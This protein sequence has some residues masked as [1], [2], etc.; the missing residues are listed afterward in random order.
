MNYVP[1]SDE[2]V[3]N[4]KP[5]YDIII[6]LSLTKWI[7]LNWGDSGLKRFFKKVYAHLQP[8][9]KF[10]LEPQSFSSYYKRKKITVCCGD[11]CKCSGCKCNE[12]NVVGVNIMSVNVVGINVKSVNVVGVSV[13]SVNI[14]GVN[15]MSLNVMSV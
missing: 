5:E 8:G 6:A 12:C 4:Q 10:I 13:M 11:T 2:M 1:V 15:V 9:G 14:V 7:H 3:Q